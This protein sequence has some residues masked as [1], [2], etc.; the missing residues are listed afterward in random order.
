ML[1]LYHLSITAVYESLSI[2]SNPR[3]NNVVY[4]FIL[5]LLETESKLKAFLIKRLKINTCHLDYLNPVFS[6]LF[7]ISFIGMKC[8][9]FGTSFFFSIRCT[10]LYSLVLLLIVNTP[11]DLILGAGTFSYD[12]DSIQF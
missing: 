12:N 6:V 2:F 9:L 1:I 5:K 7:L 4:S 8:Y 10:K 3:H 11:P